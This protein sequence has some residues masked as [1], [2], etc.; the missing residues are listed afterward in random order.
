MSGMQFGIFT[1]GDVTEDPTN[2]RTRARRSGLPRNV[3]IAQK[4]ADAGL[5]AFATAS[6]GPACGAYLAADYV[7]LHPTVGDRLA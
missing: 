7:I 2:R 4:A 1:W 5:D 6:T 3:T